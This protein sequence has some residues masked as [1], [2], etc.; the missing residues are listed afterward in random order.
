MA[1]CNEHVGRGQESRADS[2][3]LGRGAVRQNQPDATHIRLND[4]AELFP[5]R[6]LRRRTAR[7][8]GFR[9]AFP[10]QRSGARKANC[11][12][13]H[14]VLR[15][16]ELPAILKLQAGQLGSFRTPVAHNG[17]KPFERA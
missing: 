2:V 9:N 1:A 10:D 4:A 14:V 17:T 16:F 15:L 12:L 11:A 6:K 5:A 7:R 8:Q 13:K 3:L